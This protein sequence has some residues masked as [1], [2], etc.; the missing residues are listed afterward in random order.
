MINKVKDIDIKNQA[1]YFCN[2]INVKNFDLNNIKT[3]KKACKI[4]YIAYVAI[5]DSR[6]VKIN[7]VN[8]LN[9]IFSKVNGYCKE[10]N[11]N[12]YLTLVPT[13]VSKGNIKKIWGTLE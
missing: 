6:Y 3:D 1:Y 11:E 8:S 13:N 12:K 5:K 4:D 9:V 2:Y 7:S 10:I